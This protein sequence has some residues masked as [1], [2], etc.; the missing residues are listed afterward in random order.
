M[1]ST[2]GISSAAWRDDA[3]SLD[4]EWDDPYRDVLTDQLVTIRSDR[5]LLRDAFDALPLSVLRPSGP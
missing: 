3:V 1:R 2:G 5:F 4:G